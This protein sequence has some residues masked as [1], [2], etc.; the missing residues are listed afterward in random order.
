MLVTLIIIFM[1]STIL[2]ASGWVTWLVLRGLWRRQIDTDLIFWVL[3]FVLWTV[4]I[5]EL[6]DELWIFI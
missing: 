3:L 4:F 1:H 2:I 6:V 5:S